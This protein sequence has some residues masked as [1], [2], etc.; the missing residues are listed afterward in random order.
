MIKIAKLGW[1]DLSQ[2]PIAPGVYAWYYQPVITDYD[3][4]SA[5][6]EITR[7]VGQGNREGARDVVIAL[8]NERVMSYFRQDPYE[9]LLTGPL[10]PRHSGTAE[11]DQR[12]SPELVE[13]LV[14]EPHRLGPLRNI[15]A[16]STPHFA[17]PIYVG[18]SD[19]LRSRLLRHRNLIERYRKEDFRRSEEMLSGQ[20]EEAGFARR[21]VRRKIPPERLFAMICEASDV[22]GL[23]V[24][25]EN[26]FNRMYYPILGRN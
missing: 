11:H 1:S 20:S 6:S 7:L 21:V 4:N 16:A 5:V 23:H 22:E 18:M 13:R 25:A 3:L 14:N 9:I 26:L 24:D 8:L 15:L 17:S 19:N 12:I 10:K 2:A